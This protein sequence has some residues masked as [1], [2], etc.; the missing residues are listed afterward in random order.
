MTPADKKIFQVTEPLL[1]VYRPVEHI[2]NPTNNAPGAPDPQSIDKDFQP[3]AT[4]EYVAVDPATSMKRYIGFSVKYMR[5][6][7]N[8]AV[9]AGPGKDGYRHFGAALHVLEDYFAHSNFL[10]LSLRKVG[11]SKVLPWTSPAAGKHRLPVVTGMFDSDDVIASTAGLIADTL[12]K[13]EWD[14]KATK[15]GERT[16]V[17]RIM[18]ILLS[19]HSDPRLLA[20]YQDFLVVRDTIAKIP[21]HQYL[22]GAMHYTLGMVANVYNFVY[23]SLIHLVGNSVDDQQILRIGDPNTNGSTDPT[24]SQLAKDHDNHPFHTL[25][26]SLAKVAVGQVG[27]AMAARWWGGDV[28]ADPAAV[29]ASFIVHP[30]DTNWQDAMVKEWAAKHPQQ[31]L[32]GQS[33]TEWEALE[34]AHKQ[35]TIDAINKTKKQSNDIWGY[36]NKNY[37]SIFGTENQVRK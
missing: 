16:K 5:D 19:E 30:L 37:Q 10:E 33:A 15:P 12:F 22:E 3:R 4:K 24:H 2:D 21:G 13:V 31:V 8:K 17:D 7:I 32:R 29:A 27:R 35:E 26:A 20:S 1:G 23:S 11:H 25:A 14:F 28:S 6:E 9:A 36:I 18:L 34:K